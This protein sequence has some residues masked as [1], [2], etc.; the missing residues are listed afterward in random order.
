[1]SQLEGLNEVGTSCILT[2]IFSH[3]LGFE[4]SCE[5]FNDK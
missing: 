3:D 5:L 1:M 4:Q 2:K